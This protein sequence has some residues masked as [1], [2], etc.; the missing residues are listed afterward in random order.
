[1]IKLSIIV[2]VYNVEKYIRPCFE[3]IFKQGLDD[4]DFEVVIVND[5]TKDRSMEMIEDIISQ[6]NNITVINQENQGISITRNNGIEAATG[7]Y[8]QFIDSDDVLIGNTI[9]YLLEKALS[10]RVDLVVADFIKMDDEQIA[11]FDDKSFIQEDGNIQEKSGRELLL[12][13]LNPHYCHVW[14]TLYRRD[15]LNSHHLRFIP[16]IYYEDI[17]FTHQC[18]VKACRCIKINWQF[19][20]YRKGHESI[21]SDFTTPKAIAYCE[22]IA[23]TWTLSRDNG[24]DHAVRQKIRNDAFVSFSM[25]FYVLTTC[26]TISRSEKMSVLNYIKQLIP[27]LTFK[28]GLKQHIV[29]FFYRRMPTTYMTLRIIYANHL[30]YICWAIGDFVRNKKN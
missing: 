30:Q 15:F 21:T 4:A 26:K 17:P 14:H 16:G 10:S 2:P 13:D 19:I 25:L 5:G 12:Q 1:M 23:S 8:I 6:H 11:L 29:D 22:A 20:I 7:T 9:P 24:L 28:N 3:S 27:D 18:Y